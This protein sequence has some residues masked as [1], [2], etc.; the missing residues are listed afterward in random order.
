MSMPSRAAAP[1]MTTAAAAAR[2]ASASA[3][4]PTL[5]PFRNPVR[6][7]LHG[8][9]ALFALA[10]TAELVARPGLAGPERALLAGWPL[11]HFALFLVSALYHSAPWGPIARGHMQRI[12]HSMIY[13]KIAGSGSALVWLTLDGALRGGLLC[14]LWA[15]ALAGSAQKLWLPAVDE[16]ASRPVQVFQ[17]CLILPALAAFPE[18]FPGPAAAM[19]VAGGACYALGALC[20]L[21]ERPRLWPRAFSFHELFH[22]T[23]VVASALHVGMLLQ[24]LARA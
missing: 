13:V 1:T 2:L 11:C 21:L 16:R 10:A 18:R 14:G 4:H 15:I 24:Y 20:F 22:V 3:A 12:D 23:T 19:L 8:S 9:A 17:A 5:G 7:L 6:G